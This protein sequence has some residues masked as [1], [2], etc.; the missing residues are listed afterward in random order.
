MLLVWLAG[1]IWVN[2]V[3]Q[4]AY[5]HIFQHLFLILSGADPNDS[6]GES[7][8]SSSTASKPTLESFNNAL[9][10]EKIMEDLDMNTGKSIFFNAE[11]YFHHFGSPN[12]TQIQL[13]STSLLRFQ[14]SGQKTEASA[15]TR[16]TRCINIHT[17]LTHFDFT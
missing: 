3:T 8:D 2:E 7:S 11:Q 13:A 10:N 9:D 16:H 5:D 1:L 15:Y 6:T 17:N 12:M 4:E 14:A